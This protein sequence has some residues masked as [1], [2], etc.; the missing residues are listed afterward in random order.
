MHLLRIMELQ[1][2]NR[3]FRQKINKILYSINGTIF[4]FFRKRLNKI[5]FKAFQW[6]EPKRFIC[7]NGK[8]AQKKI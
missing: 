1:T 4:Y 8:R 6:L 5:S 2:N 3:Y 7:L